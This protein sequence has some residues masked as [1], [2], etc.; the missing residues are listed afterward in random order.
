MKGAF[1]S[2]VKLGA[3]SREISAGWHEDKEKAEGK[4][5]KETGHDAV[6]AVPACG[7]GYVWLQ[8]R[9]LSPIADLPRPAGICHSLETPDEYTCLTATRAVV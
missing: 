1:V 7:G 3:L 9:A 5:K 4:A 8:L 6:L 2:G